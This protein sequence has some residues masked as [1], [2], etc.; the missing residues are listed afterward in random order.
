MIFLDNASTTKISKEALDVYIRESIDE[1][2]NPSALYMPGASISQRIT[3]AKQQILKTLNANK[4]DNIIFTSGATES[5]NMV[6]NSFVTYRKKALFGIT[7]HPSVYNLAKKL[8]DQGYNIEFVNVTKEGIID[9]EDFKNKLTED[10]NFVSIM[11]VNNETGAINPIKELVKITKEKNKSIIFHTDGVQAFGKIDV[12]IDELGVDL[13]TISSHKIMGPK[14]IGLLYIKKGI[15]IKPMIIGG[16]QEQNLR[17]GTE[18]TPAIFAFAKACEQITQYQR[19]KDVNKLCQYIKQEL[20]KMSSDLRIFSNE[21]C[22]PFIISFAFPKLRAETILR[23]LEQ[24]GVLVGNGSACSS[25]KSGNRILSSMNISKEYIEGALRVSLS[26]FTTQTEIEEFLKNLK[27]I[28]F[29]YKDKT[30][31]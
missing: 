25:H 5:N 17:S 22:S 6:I 15:N 23:M 31:R 12:D 10:V 11:H 20:Y 18:N 8:F 29:E 2:Y 4:F 14:G 16:G 26:Y 9:I 3:K 27:E 24:R 30:N 7:E 28:V 21:N 1:F 13:Y 19:D